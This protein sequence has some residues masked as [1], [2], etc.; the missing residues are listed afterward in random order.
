MKV[1]GVS[2][3]AGRHSPESRGPAHGGRAW[4]QH[5]P[6]GGIGGSNAWIFWPAKTRTMVCAA[7]ASLTA[8][9]SSAS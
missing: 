9:A 4:A 5:L 7:T 8:S 2:S 6:D 3:V 1:A